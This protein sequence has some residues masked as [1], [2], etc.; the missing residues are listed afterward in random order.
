MKIAKI[1]RL[2][3]KNSLKNNW[4]GAVCG[5]MLLFS[6]FLIDAF[7][8]D[9]IYYILMAVTQN[10][11]ISSCIFLC[12]FLLLL[13]LLSPFINGYCKYFYNLVKNENN[14][15]KDIFHYFSNVKL[16]F[17]ALVFNIYKLTKSLFGIILSFIPYFVVS[18]VLKE[19][20][21]IWITV[22][23]GVVISLFLVAK[24]YIFDFVFIE[25]ENCQIQEIKYVSNLIYKRQKGEAAK[26]TVS[27][28]LW[29][30]L[31]VL[32]LPVLYVVPYMVTS[33][34]NSSKWLIE[35]Y[36]DGQIL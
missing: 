20:I 29:A 5:L 21:Y 6:L 4:I 30:L 32:V 16:Y 8:G 11:A 14:N 31:C 15:V 28:S 24:L 19:E 13:L 2:Q 35:L 9:L 22:V 1:I 12:F 25:Y 17:K 7:C 23:F 10:E 27:F 3:S 36:K 26:L 18:A 33:M 34:A